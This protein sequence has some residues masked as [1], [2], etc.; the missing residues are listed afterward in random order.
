MSIYIL[1]A[2]PLIRNNIEKLGI[3]LFLIVTI[4]LVLQL[5]IGIIEPIVTNLGRNMSFTDRTPLWKALIHLGLQEPFFGY[6][7]GGFWYGQR[8]EFLWDAVYWHPKIGHNG[9]LELFAAGGFM[10]LVFLVGIVITAYLKIKKTFFYDF[11]Y[12]AFRLPLLIMI[13][14]AN[15]TESSFAMGRDFLWFVFLLI[16]MDTPKAKT[17]EYVEILSQPA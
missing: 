14:I 11:D 4:F 3:I 2:S 16:A 5:T 13:L 15:V 17:F 6:G 1:L 10:A 8:L 7:Y 9:Y 12:G